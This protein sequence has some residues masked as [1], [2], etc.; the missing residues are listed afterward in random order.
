MFYIAKLWNLYQLLWYLFIQ[1]ALVE[2]MSTLLLPGSDVNIQFSIP[3]VLPSKNVLA[4]AGLEPSTSWFRAEYANHYTNE[5]VLA[6]SNFFISKFLFIFFL[7]LKKKHYKQKIIDKQMSK[8]KYSIQKYFIFHVWTTHQSSTH[9]NHASNGQHR[10]SLKLNI[11]PSE[12][13]KV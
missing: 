1:D 12:M 13:L 6:F 7:Q 5:A 10:S 11:P 4:L 9:H 3:G 2:I 8:R